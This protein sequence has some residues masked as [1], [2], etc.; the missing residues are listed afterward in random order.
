MFLHQQNHVNYISQLS[1]KSLSTLPSHS[2]MHLS[3][4][5]KCTNHFGLSPPSF[6]FAVPCRPAW[7]QARRTGQ[8]L[9]VSKVD[10]NTGFSEFSPFIQDSLCS[11]TRQHPPPPCSPGAPRR[12]QPNTRRDKTDY[13]C[14]DTQG[15][16]QRDM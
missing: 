11:S 15:G 1:C 8:P 7:T 2:P 3:C 10:L 12:G 13:V 9:P 6:S 5:L 4:V 16:S 14:T